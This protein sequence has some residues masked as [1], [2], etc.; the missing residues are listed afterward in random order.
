MAGRKGISARLRGSM[1]WRLE[2]KIHWF[3]GGY[4]VPWKGRRQGRHERGV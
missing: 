1:G 3:T 2:P 4:Y